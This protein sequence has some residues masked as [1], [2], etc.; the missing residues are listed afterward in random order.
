MAYDTGTVNAEQRSSA[1]FVVVGPLLEV[2]YG[3][4]EQEIAD[5]SCRD[6]GNLPLE[7]LQDRLGETLT[8]L[9]SN[10]AGKA[11]TD[12]DIGLAGEYILSLNV[13]DKVKGGLLDE[14]NASLVS[15]LP[16]MSSSPMPRSPIFGL[17][18]PRIS[19]Q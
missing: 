2:L 3:R 4:L 6:L 18:L 19:R 11:V 12:H 15:S 10:V 8:D 9:Q 13:A 14:L 5:P 7:H 1:V 16:F 17:S